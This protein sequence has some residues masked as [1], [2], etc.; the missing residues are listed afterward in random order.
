MIIASIFAA[1]RWMRAT[2]CNSF[3]PPSNPALER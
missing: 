3:L 1:P 2:A